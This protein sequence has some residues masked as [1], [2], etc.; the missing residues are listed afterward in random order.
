MRKLGV[1]FAFIFMLVAVPTADA[2]ITEVF[3]GKIPCTVQSPR[4][5]EGQTWCQGH[6]GDSNSYLATVNSFDGTPIDVNVGFPDD[7]FG[8]GPYP[9]AMYFH[10]FGGGK[11]GFN[12]DLQ[13][14][15]DQGIAVLSMTERGFKHSCGNTPSITNLETNGENCDKGFI[16]LMDTRYEVRDAQYFAGLLADEDV[17]LPKKIGAVGASYGGGKS[18]ALGALKNRIMKP[19]GT[20][21]PWVSPEGKDMEIAAAAPIVPWTDFAY[22]LLPNGRTL[23]YAKDSPYEKPFGVMKAQIVSALLPAGDNF[24][25]ENSL[26]DPNFD[27]LGWKA[28]MD[29]GEPYGGTPTAELMFHE[30]TR[31]HSSYYIDDSVEPA[32]LLIAQGLTDDL[33]PVDEPLRYYNRTKDKYPEADISLLFADIGH[34]RAPTGTPNA[35]GRP[36]DIE[37]GYQR[38][39]DWFSYYLKGKG[40]KPVNQVEVKT[41][42]CPYSQPSGGPYTGSNWAS[43]S[44]GEILVKD[45]GPRVIESGAG[46]NDAAV[47]FSTLNPG[48]TQIAEESEPGA[49]EYDLDTV[50]AGGLTLMGAPTVIADVS[51]VNGPESQIAARLLELSTDGLERIVAR[52]LY[53]PDASGA[54]VIQLHGNAYKFEPGTKLRL[55]LLPKDGLPGV[56]LGSYARPSNGQ[57]D[58]TIK[59]AE[60]RIPVKEAPGAGG[61]MVTAT[62][63]KVLPDGAE[64]AGDY[65]GVGSIP[66]SDWNKVENPPAPKFGLVNVKG[67][68]KI[69]GRKMKVKVACA[70]KHDKC[71]TSK[72]IVKGAKSLK[73]LKGRNIFVSKKG[74]IRISPGK[75]RTIK[76]GV[77]KKARTL[78][79]DHKVG[80][81]G[82]PKK[83]VRGM[84]KL[85]VQVAI[86]SGKYRAGSKAVI[87]RVGRV[88]SGSQDLHS[89]DRPLGEAIPR[90]RIALMPRPSRSRPSVAVASWP[91]RSRMRSSR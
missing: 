23:D 18:M 41:Q 27:I 20:Y 38:I 65:T 31:H 34:P 24:S 40:S 86:Y 69:K 43:M 12:G 16:H 3:D 72:V 81:R 22:A 54:Q 25:G 77:V 59:N 52:G 37:L 47:S 61:G 2:A 10:G 56:P 53:R 36:A 70:A 55:Q 66:I 58:V 14:F 79:R 30:M 63:P 76:F 13:R 89:R 88:A 75:S 7:D 78:F 67:P 87:K 80:P 62:S 83:M 50:P 32:P 15:L 51:V 91:L 85:R 19:D 21:A 48:C 11:E 68:L 42:V 73:K 60:I 49:A 9:L 29:G 4:D 33:F 44:K 74:S 8:E 45:P 84:K 6:D 5:N 17:I 46:S 64:L 35:Q 90:T 1:L 57:Q 28:L 71:R 82:G 39:D 26:L